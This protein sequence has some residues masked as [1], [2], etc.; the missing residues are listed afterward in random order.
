MQRM[1]TENEPEE[2]ESNFVSYNSIK[3]SG[4]VACFMWG[5]AKEQIEGES[6]PCKV[7]LG[8]R[9]EVR[10]INS[11]TKNK[12]GNLCLHNPLKSFIFQAKKMSTST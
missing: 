11:T 9:H 12:T 6:W 7:L 5:F 2:W 1:L 8:L 10:T 3:Y 4:M